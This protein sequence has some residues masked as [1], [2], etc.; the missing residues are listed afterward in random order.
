MNR[1]EFMAKLKALLGDIPA[2]EREEAL[3]YYEDY[4]DDAGADNEAEVIRE[5]ESPQRVA[6]M[7]KNDLKHTGNDGEFTE[8]GYEQEWASKKEVPQRKGYSYQ[9]GQTGEYSY[10]AS[11][12]RNDKLVKIALIVLIALIGCPVVIPVGVGIFGVIAG[13]LIAAVCFFA[14]LV[15]ASLAVVLAGFVVAVT[16]IGVGIAIHSFSTCSTFD[17]RDWIDPDRAW[18]TGNII[19]R[20]ALHC[21]VSGDVSVYRETVPEAVSQKG[22]V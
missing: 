8:N 11:Q 5:L 6:A 15:I 19:Y 18:S 16:G 2:D 9:S 12:G 4:F 21:N 22:G 10:E 14:A 7:I 3:Q 13:L 1:E 17:G 20:K